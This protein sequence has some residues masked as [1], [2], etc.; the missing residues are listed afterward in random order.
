M[1]A[2]PIDEFSG[3]DEFAAF[4]AGVLKR[5]KATQQTE[6]YRVLVTPDIAQWMLS[7]IDQDEH[8]HNLKQRDLAASSVAELRRSM[9]SGEFVEGCDMLAISLDGVLINGMHRAA[10]L[11]SEEM[12]HVFDIKIGLPH[13][14]TNA[15][16]IGRKRRPH[17]QLRIVG[18]L[19]NGVRPNRYAATLRLFLFGHEFKEV[20]HT[21]NELHEASRLYGDVIARACLIHKERGP[22]GRTSITAAIARALLYESEDKLTRF[23]AILC[24]D[25]EAAPHERAA[26]TLRRALTVGKELRSGSAAVRCETYRKTVTAIS[27]FCSGNPVKNIRETKE[28]PYPLKENPDNAPLFVGCYSPG[29]RQCVGRVPARPAQRLLAGSAGWTG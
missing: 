13:E 25:A 12:T 26:V 6:I 10:C 19:P 11:V 18:G 4:V 17:E 14:N 24:D 1:P 5:V 8:G 21:A 20:K 3:P 7:T 16:D 27:H 22:V 9:Q 29:A 15:I 2:M 28:D 23:C